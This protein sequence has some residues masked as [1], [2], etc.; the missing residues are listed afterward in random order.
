MYVY[1]NNNEPEHFNALV[2][3]HIIWRRVNTATEPL[4]E[5]S[6]AFRRPLSLLTVLFSRIYREFVLLFLAGR[7]KSPGYKLSPEVDI[8]LIL[9][10]A[11]D[12]SNTTCTKTKWIVFFSVEILKSS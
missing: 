5:R 2:V 12:T 1:T 4:I 6:P 11:F 3:L 7:G 8:P 9:F 10:R